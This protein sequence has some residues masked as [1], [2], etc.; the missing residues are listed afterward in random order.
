[1]TSKTALE[2]RKSSIHGKGVFATRR[3]QRDENLGV[4]GG[5]RTRRNGTYVL[6]VEYDEGEVVGISG[7]TRLRYLNHSALPNAV[8]YGDELFAL[9]EIQPGSE[10]T[11]DYGEDWAHVDASVPSSADT[12]IGA[13]NSAE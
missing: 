4:Y 10:V 2:V 3:I 13:A 11:I 6:W 5:V 12:L 1:V 7:R 8:F 9:C